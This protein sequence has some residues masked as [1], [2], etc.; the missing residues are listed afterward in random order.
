[1]NTTSVPTTMIVATGKMPNRDVRDAELAETGH[2][3]GFVDQL[4]LPIYSG[5]R[6]GH[7]RQGRRDAM[8]PKAITEE[9][10]VTEHVF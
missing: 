3:R 4:F 10:T 5:T 1:M 8:S 2:R 6:L 9:R 7:P